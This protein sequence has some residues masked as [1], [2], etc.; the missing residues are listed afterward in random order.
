MNK[1]LNKS[2]NIFKFSSHSD[3]SPMFS[4]KDR[5][6]F[7]RVE[8]TL[9]SLASHDRID[10]TITVN[11]EKTD[12]FGMLYLLRELDMGALGTQSAS[13][14]GSTR[15]VHDGIEVSQYWRPISNFP[16][17]RLAT[18]TQSFLKVFFGYAE[19]AHFDGRIQIAVAIEDASRITADTVPGNGFVAA[20]FGV[21]ELQ[22]L[23]ANPPLAW[24]DGIVSRAEHA[25]KILHRVKRVATEFPNTVVVSPLGHLGSLKWGLR[26]HPSNFCGYSTPTCQDSACVFLWSIGRLQVMT[27]AAVADHF[28]SQSANSIARDWMGG[29]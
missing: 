8:G 10:Y 15:F 27:I 12:A 20:S 17:T 7:D 1:S 21:D 24:R 2:L 13:D 11:H 9:T 14:F 16:D 23:A 19:K 4:E 3:A 26:I 5:E 29:P 28:L 6:V 25:K 18:P 22:T